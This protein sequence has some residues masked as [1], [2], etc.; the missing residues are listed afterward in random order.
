MIKKRP[1]TQILSAYGGVKNYRPAFALWRFCRM[2]L[3]ERWVLRITYRYSGLYPFP[4]VLLQERRDHRDVLLFVVFYK[5]PLKFRHMIFW[6]HQEA[7]AMDNQ[8]VIR[9]MTAARLF[10]SKKTAFSCNTGTAKWQC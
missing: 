7:P 4:A 3:P 9:K 1:R 6:N 5:Q 2:G 8:I 10:P